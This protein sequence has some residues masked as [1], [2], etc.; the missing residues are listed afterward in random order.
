MASSKTP[1]RL[2]TLE[3]VADYLN[4][5]ASTLRRW[6]VEHTGPVALKVGRVLRYDPA[7]LTRWVNSRR[8]M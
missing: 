5:P 7:D 1:D 6:R 3:E 8:G 2:L 4:V